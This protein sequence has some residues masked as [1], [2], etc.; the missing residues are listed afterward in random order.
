[1]ELTAAMEALKA[2]PGPLEVYS[3]SNYVVKCFNDRWYVGWEAK[4]WK[5]SKRQ[6]V[7]NQDLWRPMV[8]LFRLRATELKFTWVKAHSEH[9][10][11]D[12]VDRLAVEA[13]TQQN[14]RSGTG[15]PSDLGPPDS[16]AKSISPRTAASPLAQI[17]GWRLAVFGHRPQQLGGYDANNP[18]AKHV[19]TKLAEMLAALHVVHSDL[20]VLTGLDL[21]AEM[22]AAEAAAEAN[23]PYIAVLPFPDPDAMWPE[24]TRARYRRALAGAANVIELGKKQPRTRQEAGKGIGMRNAAL[25]GAANGALV[26]W[27]ERDRNIGELVSSL[28]RHIPDDVLV[29]PPS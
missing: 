17:S 15:I 3:D 22:L 29:L 1:M 4:G 25:V 11:N 9:P 5:N 2:I 21:G 10:M 28:E 19:R 24:L 8:E 20:I 16:P 27:D 14:A 18:T 23:V 26:V 13:A 6:P 12:L 7:E